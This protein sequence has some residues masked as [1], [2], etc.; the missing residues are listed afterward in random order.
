MKSA[1]NKIP[2]EI[3]VAPLTPTEMQEYSRI[4]ELEVV[5]EKECYDRGDH[6]KGVNVPGESILVRPDS[7]KDVGD[8]EFDFRSKAAKLVRF[9]I[10]K[11]ILKLRKFDIRIWQPAV[12]KGW[13]TVFRKDVVPMNGRR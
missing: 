12:V 8:A 13:F 4:Q 6:Y 10:H 1:M 5:F 9:L 3:K 2:E 11:H 7:H